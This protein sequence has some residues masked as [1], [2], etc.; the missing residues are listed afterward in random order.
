MPYSTD[1]ANMLATQLEE[2]TT[3]YAHHLVGQFANAEF[4]DVFRTS[5]RA[6][7]FIAAA[8]SL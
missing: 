1:Q 2:F 4:F 8:R 7:P 6:Q 5:A 3:S